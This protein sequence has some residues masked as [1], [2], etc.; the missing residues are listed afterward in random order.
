MFVSEPSYST[1]FNPALSIECIIGEFDNKYNLSYS[2]QSDTM[3]YSR[4]MR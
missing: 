3:S 4:G 2:R 1:N